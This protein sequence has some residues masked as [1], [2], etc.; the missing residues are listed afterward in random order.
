MILVLD[1]NPEW[2]KIFEREASKI[3]TALGYEAKG[4]FGIPGRRYFRLDDATGLRTH[5]VHSFEIRSHNVIRHLAFRDYMRAH[6][7]IAA[8]YGELKQRLARENPHDMAAYIDGKDFF[9]KNH[10][11]R[12]LHWAS[13]DTNKIILKKM[14]RILNVIEYPE[15][16]EKAIA[17]IHNKWGRANNLNYYSDAIK[18][19]T[20]HP[21]GLPRFYLMVDD[22][23]EIV[24]CFALVTNDFISRHDLYPW[25]ACVYVES[26][27]RGKRLSELM[28]EHAKTEAATAGY[29]EVFLTTDHDNFYEKF[30]WARMEDGYSSDGQVSKIYRITVSLS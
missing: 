17:Y 24:G 4:E 30:G 12:A 7:D 19:S 1:H 14:Y 11:R 26:L 28:F 9:V 25:L 23:N 3:R 18:H 29:K 13:S 2:A 5:Q 21:T 10:E 15:G 16:L 20:H 6:A 8:E 27:H 22:D